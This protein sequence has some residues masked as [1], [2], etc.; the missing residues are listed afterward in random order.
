MTTKS[1]DLNTNAPVLTDAQRRI[2]ELAW[3]D[4]FSRFLD[5]RFRVPGTQMRFG[6]DFLLGLIPYAGDVIS[7]GMS[8]V[9]IAT[10][11]RHGASGMLIA[12]MLGNAA[13]D[14]TVGAIPILGDLFDLVYKANVRNLKLMREH[15]QEGRH[16][17]SAWPVLIV[18]LLVILGMIVFIG[19]L[20]WQIFSFAWAVIAG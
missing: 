10:M 8:G 5:T 3:V 2:P 18:I 1:S 7:L 6:A 17:G 12:R 19:W 15:Y 9:M 4:T 14:A 11:A 16:Q 20:A 13:L